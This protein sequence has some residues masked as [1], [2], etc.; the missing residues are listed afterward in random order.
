MTQ[1]APPTTPRPAPA[2]YTADD[3]TKEFRT[4]KYESSRAAYLSTCS[5]FAS[6]WVY[7]AWTSLFSV[8]AIKHYDSHQAEKAAINAFNVAKQTLSTVFAAALA[9]PAVIST[10][11]DTPAQNAAQINSDAREP[12]LKAFYDAFTARV[13]QLD[14]GSPNA[15]ARTAFLTDGL[16][17]GI[18]ETAAKHNL[19]KMAKD[20][21]S[22]VKLEQM[23]A[24]VGT[25]SLM[26]TVSSMSPA[27]LKIKDFTEAVEKHTNLFSN[28]KSNVGLAATAEA[29]RVELA[30]TKG[31]QVAPA[32][33]DL[34]KPATINAAKA[35]K[36]ALIDASI[37]ALVTELTTLRDATKPGSLHQ[38]W[39]ER[40]AKEAILNTALA[41]YNTAAG[42][43]VTTVAGI[44]AALTLV[45][46]LAGTP[47]VA[48]LKTAFDAFNVAAVAFTKANDRQIE[49]AGSVEC[50][51]NDS[52]GK[53]HAGLHPTLVAQ[54][55]GV[56]AI[57]AVETRV[58]CE[59]L[60][61]CA[62]TAPQAGFA[63][64]LGY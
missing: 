22:S 5:N 30:K 35:A 44:A 31:G 27:T 51:S 19:G 20:Q 55:T 61:M 24:G 56:D 14:K 25:Q 50:G 7:T 43:A 16:V 3:A 62:S 36:E 37:N 38:L 41:A 42:G 63:A 49:I 48:N 52:T 47:A 28:D 45:S 60:N 23:I 46:T 10:M 6:R 57:V 58:R 17:K 2:T 8:D 11:T 1:P 59:F 53:N 39:N 34:N 9:N 18:R 54:K 29:M 4:T 13:E 64:A 21:L 32:V 33:T 40:A 15:A 12:A 26:H